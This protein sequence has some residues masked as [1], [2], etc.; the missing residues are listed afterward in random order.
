MI[1]L[2]PF[3][4]YHDDTFFKLMTVIFTLLTSKIFLNTLV[5]EDID[6][7]LLIISTLISLMYTVSF[8]LQEHISSKGVIFTHFDIRRIKNYNIIKILLN[9]R[10]QVT[11]YGLY[12][13]QRRFQDLS[14][15]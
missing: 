12:R 8:Y 7:L 11:T 1:L 5:V 10:K 9:K 13:I 2:M 15:G 3:C 6:T 14:D 4:I